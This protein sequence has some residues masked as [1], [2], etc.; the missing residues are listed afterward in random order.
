MSVQRRGDGYVVRWREGGK[1]HNR[2]F[3]TRKDADRFDRL[4]KDRTDARRAG[5]PVA[6]PVREIVLDDLCERVLAQ[7]Q[8]SPRTIETLRERLAY[9]RSAF[10]PLPVRELL[11]EEIGRWNAALPLHPTTRA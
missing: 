5:L 8:A 1:Q 2:T 7:H 4:M 11:P 6:E 3:R 9:A 10:G